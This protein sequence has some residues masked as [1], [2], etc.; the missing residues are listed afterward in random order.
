MKGAVFIA[1]NEMIESTTSINVWEQLLD[2]VQPNSGGIYTSV[3]DYPDEELFALVEA[4]S[5][6]T[7]T[8]ANVLVEAFGKSLF[9][10]L[11]SKYP[12]FSA[13]EKTFF[14]F[15]K[16]IDG[17]I[18]KEVNKLYTN[19]CLPSIQCEQTSENE[20]ILFY[21]SPRKL[22]ILAEGLIAGAAQYYNVN[23]SIS[24]PVCMHKGADKC[25]LILTLNSSS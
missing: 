19:A 14:D 3:E 15:I 1:F 11:N 24:H 6:I 9:E 21:S 17:T 25:Q 13:Q 16:S 5:D 7:D 18:H 10:S 20:L 2:R 12:Q 22:C 4:L 23:C 8:P